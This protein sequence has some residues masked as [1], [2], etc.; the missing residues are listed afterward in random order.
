MSINEFG[1]NSDIVNYFPLEEY[2]SKIKLLPSLLEHL[3]YTSQNFDN[4]MNNLFKHDEN[5]VI[6]YWIYL[7]YDELSSSQKIENQIFNESSL[8]QKNIYF[9]TLNMNHKRIFNLHNFV[10]EGDLP[11]TYS[12]RKT[13]VNV[14]TIHEDGSEDVFWKGAKAEDV[15]KFM[16]DFIKVYKFKG[17]HPLYS[18]PFLFSALIHLLFIRIHPFTDGNGRTA[19]I[20][21]NI[22]FTE[23][24]NKLYGTRLKLSPLNLS[25]SL[26]VN[27][28]TYHK[29]LNNIY[30]DLEHDSNE[31]INNWLDF[32]LDMTDEQIYFASNILE[33]YDGSNAYENSKIAPDMRIRKIRS[34][35]EKIY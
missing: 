34:T 22:K 17:T 19:R 10:T 29:R 31:A 9:D 16:N 21:H 2:I 15:Q 30:F 11:E 32:I 8:S 12:Y 6:D 13:E 7:L 23:S 14:S 3:N 28:I 20:I 24:I 26:L 18:S 1:M 33:N 35:K 4:Y 5:Y 25:H 27:K